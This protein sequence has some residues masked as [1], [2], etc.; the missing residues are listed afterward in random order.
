MFTR[1]LTKGVA[2]SCLKFRGDFERKI[3][4]KYKMST[5]ENCLLHFN[6]TVTRF[7]AKYPVDVPD[8]FVVGFTLTHKYN[9]RSKY[10]DVRVSYVDTNGL[11]DQQV[12]DLAWSRLE[13]SFVDWGSAVCG[14]CHIIGS[15]YV[16]PSVA[17][18]LAA[19][20]AM[21]PPPSE[22]NTIEEPP[23]TV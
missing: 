16:P 20:A 15:A 7:D 10:I 17:S 18:A 21:V 3:A 4:D 22:P 23:T 8:S 6:V 11:D 5:E 13:Q 1:T 2:N 14:Q 19:Q 12:I 9:G